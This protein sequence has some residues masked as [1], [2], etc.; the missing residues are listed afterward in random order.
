MRHF[1][2]LPRDTNKAAMM[3]EKPSGLNFAI[4]AA[5]FFSRAN[6]LSH[7]HQLLYLRCSIY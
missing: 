2:V 5:T 6:I 3:S 7:K 4:I 1:G